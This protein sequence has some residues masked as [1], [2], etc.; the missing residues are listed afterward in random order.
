[1][2]RL[3]DQTAFDAALARLIAQD[4]LIATLI[5]AARPLLRQREPGFAGLAAIVIGQQVS[6]AAADAIFARLSAHVG[7]VTAAAVQ[8]TGDDALRACGLSTGK[9]ATLRALAEAVSA[10]GLDL[11][12][13]A[14]HDP[15][16]ARAR[17]TAIRGIGPWTADVF[18]LFGLG[19][20]DIWPAGD[21]ALQEAARL[22]LG[23]AARPGPAEA[24]AIAERWRPLRGVAAH[25]LWL[26]YGSARAA[27]A[28]G[29][30]TKTGTRKKT[31]T[32]DGRQT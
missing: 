14:T 9:I 4:P 20:A 23:L 22:A 19:H 7:E 15:D 28:A 1:M 16:I 24:A 27:R 32:R 25:C 11:A 26:Y 8:A 10:G 6:P 17:L 31:G 12:D 29:S 18:L 2:T 5:G 21:L 3:T 13:L 30:R